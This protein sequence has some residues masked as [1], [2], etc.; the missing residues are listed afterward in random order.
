MSLFSPFLKRPHRT[1]LNGKL[2]TMVCGMVLTACLPVN[3]SVPALTP[4]SAHAEIYAEDNSRN[5][6]PL[7][8]PNQLP[9]QNVPVSLSLRGANVRDVLRGLGR[10]GRFNIM[11]DEAVSGTVSVDLHDV[12]MPA[13]L[14]AI[15][16]QNNLHYAMGG[17]NTLLVFSR[18][19][20]ND[21]ALRRTHTDI[22]PLH[23][24]NA[25]VIANVLNGTIFAPNNR[26][27]RGM[28]GANGQP[29]LA[30]TPDFRTNS[31]IVVGTEQDVIVTRDFVDQ[32]DKPRESKTWRLS[33]A[34]ALDV[35][36]LLGATLFNEGTGAISTG[37]GGGGAGGGGLGG[38]GGG[39]AGG[40]GG[41]GG[42]GMGGNALVGMS[43][44]LLRVRSEDITE[45]TGSNTAGTS[46]GGSGGA[47][48]EIEVRAL[49]KTDETISIS[50]LGAIILPDTR[51]NTITIMGT[52]QQ[53]TLAENMIARLDQRAPQVVIEA[54]LVEVSETTGK[55]L[56]FNMGIDQKDFATSFNNLRP[57][58]ATNVL[59]GTTPFTQ[60]GVANNATNPFRSLF[61]FNT[62]PNT[63]TANDF[64]YQ[65]NAL[66]KN[67]RAKIL[68]NPNLIT[69]HDKEA[70]IS[71]VDE[72]VE[73]VTVTLDSATG[74]TIG[75]ETNIGEV[76][77]ILNILPKVGANGAI[78]MRIKPSLS[79]IASIIT[80]PNGNQI[81][82]LSRREAVS[83]NIKLR[84]GETFVMGGLIQETD[85]NSLAKYPGLS[86]LPIIGALMRNSNRNHS[87]TELLVVLTPHIVKEDTTGPG[88]LPGLQQPHVV[89]TLSMEDFP[90]IPK[91]SSPQPTIEQWTPPP[92]VEQALPVRAMW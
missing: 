74:G 43:P 37:T 26:R 29:L 39:G 15:G 6:L 91:R 21:Q 8:S 30:I 49:S 70:V 77:I 45:G 63:G 7:N 54:M 10:S 87:R 84:D 24:T 3:V 67:E 12:P 36:T 32:L 40:A 34:D 57:G 50:P 16:T 22:I 55:E 58:I 80:D 9:G 66:V 27:G 92:P 88:V 78:N 17:N 51:L 68:A 44:S 31:L 18:D 11:I 61:R 4:P 47:A 52:Q 76:G 42:G 28:S 86:D 5:V 69:L 75:S 83:Q 14:Q 53:I 64:F 48:Q 46:S 35:A 19:T 23:Y 1:P 13:V 81:T 38:A 2:A 62:R 90:A 60:I 59:G 79:T 89:N 73:S 56:G 25:A 41:A 20:V 72:V 65:I 33:H 82:L 71:I 85:T